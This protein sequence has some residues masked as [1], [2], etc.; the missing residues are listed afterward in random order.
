M[1]MF[2]EVVFVLASFGTFWV[3]ETLI[4][5]SLFCLIVFT[6]LKFQLILASVMQI[7]IVDGNGLVHF[8]IKLACVKI[9]CMKKS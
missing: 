1:H 4:K 9:T 5:T 2:Y 7:H 8:P 6:F 3:I